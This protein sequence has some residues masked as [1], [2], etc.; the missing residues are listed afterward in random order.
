MG[1]QE[2]NLGLPR[3]KY[4]L[5]A[6]MPCSGP[7]HME[8]KGGGLVEGREVSII[9]QCP[10]TTDNAK[11]KKQCQGRALASAC[12]A[13]TKPTYIPVLR[14]PLWAL[15]TLSNRVKMAAS[16]QFNNRFSGKLSN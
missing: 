10:E 16:E 6:Y 9:W 7:Q 4:A 14:S 13:Y 15:K 2:S 11:G 12:K 5:Q 1:G 3:A 8:K